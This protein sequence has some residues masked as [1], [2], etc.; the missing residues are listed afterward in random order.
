M[1]AADV[2]LHEFSDIGTCA[3]AMQ[4]DLRDLPQTKGFNEAVCTYVTYIYIQTD[5]SSEGFVRVARPLGRSILNQPRTRV[6]I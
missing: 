3:P 4:P 1:I 5:C 6:L 2:M